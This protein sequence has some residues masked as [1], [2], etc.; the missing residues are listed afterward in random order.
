VCSFDRIPALTGG[1]VTVDSGPLDPS[2]IVYTS[3]AEAVVKYIKFD[4]LKQDPYAHVL[5]TEDAMA[6]DDG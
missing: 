6:A 1:V 2:D 3:M 5:D 4:S